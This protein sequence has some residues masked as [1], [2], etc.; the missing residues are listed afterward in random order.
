MFGTGSVPSS[1]KRMGRHLLSYSHNMTFVYHW[2][3]FFSKLRLYT[4]L[5]LSFV[6][7]HQEKKY[8]KIVGIFKKMNE[9]IKLIPPNHTKSIYPSHK[10]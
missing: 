2:T 9:K 10:Y 4:H 7:G 8:K 6:R 1:D 5:G 3:T